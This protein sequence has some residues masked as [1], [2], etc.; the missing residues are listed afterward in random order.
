MRLLNSPDHHSSDLAAPDRNEV[1]GMLVRG[2]KF[3]LLA[4]RFGRV[5]LGP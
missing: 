2:M 1:R 5:W 3:A 4:V